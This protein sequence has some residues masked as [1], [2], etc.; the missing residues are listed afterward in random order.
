MHP[1]D[2]VELAID[3]RL[4]ET[5][6]APTV[7]ELTTQLGEDARNAIA[8]LVRAVYLQGYGDASTATK[9]HPDAIY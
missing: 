2:R 5:D 7:E 9:I 4:L 8:A 3:L 6:I 1:F